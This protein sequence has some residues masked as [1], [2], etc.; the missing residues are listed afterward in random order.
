MDNISPPKK[1]KKCSHSNERLQLL[2]KISEHDPVI[3]PPIHD[4]WD[5]N[6]HVFMSMSKIVKKFPSYK[7]AQI[8]LQISQLIGNAELEGLQCEPYISY[9]TASISASSSL[10]STPTPSTS[11]IN[12]HINF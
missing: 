4:Q 2:K 7:Q 6:D 10:S 5:E 8:R 3:I 1:I 11:A 12:D 9:N